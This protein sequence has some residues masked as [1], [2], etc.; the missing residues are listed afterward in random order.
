MTIAAADDVDVLIAPWALLLDEALNR[1]V[2]DTL[3]RE[4]PGQPRNR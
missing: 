4:G 3:G 2:A 1:P